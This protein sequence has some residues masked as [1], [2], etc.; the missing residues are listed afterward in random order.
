MNYSIKE[1]HCNV[2]V[3]VH[4]C[5]FILKMTFIAFF[6]LVSGESCLDFFQFSFYISVF[7][8]HDQALMT[9][10]QRPEQQSQIC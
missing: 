2:T 9:S 7:S 6:H 10:S 1:Y 3:Y 5:I 8:F 4:T